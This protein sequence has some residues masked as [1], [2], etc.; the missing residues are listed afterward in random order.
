MITSTDLLINQKCSKNTDSLKT[1]ILTVALF[2]NV[3]IA[4][5]KIKVYRI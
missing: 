5:P 2:R 1:T 3:Y 4:A